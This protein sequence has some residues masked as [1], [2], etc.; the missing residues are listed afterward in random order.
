MAYEDKPKKK[1]K[2]KPFSYVLCRGLQKQIHF[3]KS[4]ST[5]IISVYLW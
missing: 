5:L 1:T 3:H 2:M 4:G